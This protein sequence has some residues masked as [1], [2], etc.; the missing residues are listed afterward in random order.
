[1]TEP[2]A[3]R[4]DSRVRVD[5]SA[6]DVEVVA[7]LKEDFEHKN[8]RHAMLRNIGKPTWSEPRKYVTW[9]ESDDGSCLTFPRGGLQ[10]VREVLRA[11]GHTWSV[12]D[13]RTEGAPDLRGRIPDHRVEL[14][15]HQEHA[16]V[17]AIARQNCIVRAPTG[18][19]KTT[20]GFAVAARLKLPTLVIVPTKGIFKQWLKRATVELG[21]K[22]RDVG[23][24]Q[25]K[26]RRIAPLTIAM[27]KTVSLMIESG[28]HDVLESF[29]LVLGDEVHLYAARTF[30]GAVDPIP[31][32]Y[33]VGFSADEHRQD[34]KEFLIYDVFGQVACTV[35]RQAVIDRGH[36]VDTEVF[37]VPTDFEAPWYGVPEEEPEEGEEEKDLDFDRLLKEM[38]ADEPRS[39]LVTWCA[40]HVLEQG[41]QLLVMAH[42]RE[43]CRAI[44]AALVARGVSSGFLIGG[45]DYEAEFDRSIAG[46]TEGRVR[47]AVGTIQAIGYG[48]DLP[49]IGDVLLSTP[50]AGNK[51]LFN[52]IRGRVCRGSKGKTDSRFFYLWDREVYG[53]R[54]LRNLM[55]WNKRVF[56]LSRRGGHGDTSMWVDARQYLKGGGRAA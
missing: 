39:E 30:F 47:C 41:R 35:E 18:S 4:V 3:I 11:A 16:V 6:L 12:D 23:V 5:A 46:L 54:H 1:M 40:A 56:V 44:D 9:E 28:D 50:V 24:I 32:K 27:Q 21:I 20:M 49:A 55:R 19:G 22:P 53:T 38:A 52:Q 14:W 13:G 17:A 51:Y 7:R 25:G 10:R 36:I 43:H 37:V 33:R 42:Q 48:I 8:P 31:A 29:G 2:I 45:Q 34:R 26:T 15:D